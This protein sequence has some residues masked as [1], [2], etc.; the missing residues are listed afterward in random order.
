M[1]GTCVLYVMQQ[2]DAMWCAGISFSCRQSVTL[3]KV[4]CL[5]THSLLLNLLPMPYSVRFWLSH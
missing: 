3:Q 1:F 2:L 5:S 4:V